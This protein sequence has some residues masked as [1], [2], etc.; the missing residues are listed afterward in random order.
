[1]TV[2]YATFSPGKPLTPL[3]LQHTHT[4]KKGLL[5]YQTIEFIN[6]L[7]ELSQQHHFEIRLNAK[8]SDSK[9]TLNASYLR[10]LLLNVDNYLTLPFSKVRDLEEDITGFLSEYTQDTNTYVQLEAVIPQVVEET[11]WDDD[12]NMTFYSDYLLFDDFYGSQSNKAKHLMLEDQI[13]HGTLADE[14]YVINIEN[15]KAELINYDYRGTARHKTAIRN[16]QRNVELVQTLAQ[17]LDGVKEYVPNTTIET[18]S[19]ALSKTMKTIQKH[20]GK[21]DELVTNGQL[22]TNRR[23][24]FNYASMTGGRSLFA[25]VVFNVSYIR[26]DYDILNRVTYPKITEDFPLYFNIIRD[27][28]ENR[29]TFG[30]NH[31]P[32]L[33]IQNLRNVNET[34]DLNLTR[35]HTVFA[36]SYIKFEQI[37]QLYIDITEHKTITN[38]IYD[39]GDYYCYAG[40]QF[41]AQVDVNY[42][43]YKKV[44]EEDKNDVKE[45]IQSFIDNQF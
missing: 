31:Q 8:I 5:M 35:L 40:N 13:G 27:D 33:S 2:T 11:D 16:Y 14:D 18:E 24:T 39:G 26:P 44:T 45:M 6:G 9:I 4:T 34:N 23:L 22:A 3:F 10:I 7:T 37:R 1:M 21:L 12:D 17:L 25:G 20:I 43:L 30:Y 36:T 38:V 19:T 29:T 41:V 32:A 28:M 42:G 15:G